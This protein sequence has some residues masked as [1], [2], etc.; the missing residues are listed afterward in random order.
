MRTGEAAAAV[1]WGVED[2]RRVLGNDGDRHHMSLSVINLSAISPEEFTT[3][4]RTAGMFLKL[5]WSIPGQMYAYAGQI[6]LPMKRREFLRR[7]LAGTALAAAGASS[8]RNDCLGGSEPPKVPG[9]FTSPSSNRFVRMFPRPAGYHATSSSEREAWLIKLGENMKDDPNSRP[10]QKHP[11]PMAGY[12][13]LGQFISHDLTFD[14]TPLE[15]VQPDAARM[16]NLRTPFLDLDHVY[17]GGPN[18]SSFLYDRQSKP[19]EEKF[20]VGETA[21]SI[22]NGRNFPSTQDDL[23]RNAQGIA[24]VGDPRQDENLIIA[25]LHVAFLK[26]HNRVLESLRRGEIEKSKG[27]LFDQARRIVT[28]HYQWVVRYDFLRQVLDPQVFEQTVRKD[29][30]RKGDEEE[31]QIPIEYALAAGRFGHSM[32]RD[33]YFINDV[34]P[35]AGLRSDVAR[36]TGRLGGASPRLPADWLISW[37][38]FFFVGAGS[39]MARHSR[40]IDTRVAAG[41]FEADRP[42]APPLPVKTLLRGHRAELPSGQEVAR[43]CDLEPLDPGQIADGPDKEILTDSGFDRETP[44]WYYILKEAEV[45]ARGAHLGELGSMLVANVIMPALARDPE[46][47]QS[48]EPGWVPTLSGPENPELFGMPYLL[49]FANVVG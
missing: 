38:R 5:G 47:Y 34:H 17:G 20:L 8:F 40:A 31:F 3:I 36:L 21:P 4:D 30:R 2:R 24:L 11:P 15:Q 7:S 35:E 1:S 42:G 10:D 6:W 28:W 19:G 14:L 45:T 16:S 27:S 13:Y 23:P 46:S 33:E 41:L 37:E 44:L 48:M 26:L 22:I 29:V 32:V 18:V 9:S 39:G 49:R 25:Q 12:T 43:A